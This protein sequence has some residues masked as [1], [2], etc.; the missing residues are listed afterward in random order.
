[1]AVTSMKV[2]IVKSRVTGQ[3]GSASVAESAPARGQAATITAA[4]R[5]R[6]WLEVAEDAGAE[7]QQHKRF[8]MAMRPSRATTQ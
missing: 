5:A 8:V 3:T 4:L 7:R 1:M 6:G 2:K